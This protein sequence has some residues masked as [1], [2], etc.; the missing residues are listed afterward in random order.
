MANIY[1]FKKQNSYANFYLGKYY[2]LLKNPQKAKELWQEALKTQPKLN[3][4]LK[5]EVL[6]L[7]D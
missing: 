7:V 3:E 4:A 1:H 2:F 5:L 6:E